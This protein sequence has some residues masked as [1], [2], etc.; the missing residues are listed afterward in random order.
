MRFGLYRASL[1]LP[2]GL[3]GGNGGVDVLGD[4]ITTVQHATSHVL[5][6]SWIAFHH[7]VGRLET[8]VGNFSNGKLF[9]VCLLGADDGSICDQWEMDTWVWHQVSLELG[10][11]HIKCTIETKG[12]GD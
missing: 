4:D 2:L 11:I 9:M 10:K 5:S 7:L 3:D 6:M 8:G 1:N 12:C